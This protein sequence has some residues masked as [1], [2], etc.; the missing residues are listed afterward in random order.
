MDPYKHYYP[1][2]SF[3]NAVR[4]IYHRHLPL[5]K[6]G[7]QDF[8]S[9]QLINLRE[10][11]LPEIQA[12]SRQGIGFYQ[13]SKQQVF[14]EMLYASKEHCV[15][16]VVSPYYPRYDPIPWHVSR[17]YEINCQLYGQ[18][19]FCIGNQTLVLEEGDLLLTPP[20]VWMTGGVFDDQGIL[21]AFRLRSSE[22][23]RSL[24]ILMGLNC[25][26]SDFLKETISGERPDAWRRYHLGTNHPF[27]RW[28]DLLET[29][30]W[31]V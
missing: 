25:G 27:G 26:L 15:A 20:G 19:V 4:E 28:F 5:L 1:M 23:H 2:S 31:I 7:V 11:M 3:E 6:K 10:D 21:R 12:L 14:H 22:F 30:P 8:T 16:S 17:Y 18:S 29:I 9:Q 24:Q 13:H